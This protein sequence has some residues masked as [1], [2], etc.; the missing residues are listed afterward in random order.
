[1]MRT[2][3][4]ILPSTAPAKGSRNLLTT[5]SDSAPTSVPQRLPTYIM[6]LFGKYL[7]YELLALALD[8]VWGF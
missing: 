8:L 6:S 4:R 5:P 2:S 1:M 7:T 3:T